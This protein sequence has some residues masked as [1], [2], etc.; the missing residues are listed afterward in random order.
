MLLAWL[1]G[2]VAV[3]LG[4]VA[5]FGLALLT[6]GVPLLRPRYH[7]QL[8]F[9]HRVMLHL[10]NRDTLQG[11]LWEDRGELVV[12]REATCLAWAEVET[13]RQRGMRP[14][15]PRELGGE[16]VIERNRIEWAQVEPPAP[17][18][19]KEKAQ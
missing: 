10:S 6:T 9:K 18:V 4:L 5:G 2:S 19:I 11:L 15:P 14:P 7:R 12:L 17:V 16:V 13:A 3:L 1:L 8:L